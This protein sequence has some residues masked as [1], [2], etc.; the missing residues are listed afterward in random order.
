[1]PDPTGVGIG[2]LLAGLARRLIWSEK[3]FPACNA[4]IVP[5]G[6]GLPFSRRVVVHTTMEGTVTIVP[7]KPTE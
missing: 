1:M 5:E 7:V 3:D 2:A 4:K 6:R